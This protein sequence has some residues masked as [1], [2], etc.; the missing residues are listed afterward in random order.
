MM[1][2]EAE[3][4]RTQVKECGY[5]SREQENSFSSRAPRECAALQTPWPFSESLQQP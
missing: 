5:A 1:E 2:A 3:V 4:M